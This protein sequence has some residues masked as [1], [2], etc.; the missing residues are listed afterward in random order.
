MAAASTPASTPI[1]RLKISAESPNC[2]ETGTPLAIRAQT[3]REAAFTVADVTV[4]GDIERLVADTVRQFGGVYTLVNNSGGPPAG[5]FDSLGDAAWQSAFE[6]NLLSYIRAIRAV[7]KRHVRAG[8]EMQLY[9]A[10]RTKHCFLIGRARCI[11]IEEIGFLIR[12]DRLM[13][14]LNRAPRGSGGRHHVWDGFARADG[15][16]D[17]KEMHEFWRKE[18]GLGVWRG[19][20]IRWEPLK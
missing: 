19:V 7:R 17:A 1:T 9:C 5:T 11:S 18:H 15:F 14:D 2:R 12:N 3:G 6:L 4:P 16:A 10:Q 8:E 20:L 13:F